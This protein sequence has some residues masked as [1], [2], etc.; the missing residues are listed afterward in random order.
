ML[1]SIPS[2]KAAFGLEFSHHRWV[3]VKAN[4]LRQ[5]TPEPSRPWVPSRVDG[6]EW[7]RKTRK[8]LEIVL[9]LKLE[10]VGQKNL[11]LQKVGGSPSTLKKEI[12]L[13]DLDASHQSTIGEG[14]FG[15]IYETRLQV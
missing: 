5:I 7:L 12:A 3:A 11:R 4:M 2:V 14:S 9:W 13:Q 15:I 1:P 6:I 8:R 10:S